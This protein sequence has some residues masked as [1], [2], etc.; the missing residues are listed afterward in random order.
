MK[1][2]FV[3]TVKYTEDGNPLENTAKYYW[4]D[5]DQF[6]L[7]NACRGAFHESVGDVDNREGVED[8]LEYQ[9]NYKQG[10]I[11]KNRYE[12]LPEIS[13]VFL[14]YNRTVPNIKTELEKTPE[15]QE[16]DRMSV[17]VETLAAIQPHHEPAYRPANKQ[18][19]QSKQSASQDDKQ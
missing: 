4:Y 6:E 5:G 11:V 18:P 17:L 3:K 19:Q 12:E 13:G 7:Q 10:E 16:E 15:Q 1:I 9:L 14:D 8:Y 2:Y